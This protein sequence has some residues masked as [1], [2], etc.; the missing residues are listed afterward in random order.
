VFA[1]VAFYLQQHGW[2]SGQAWGRE[3]T[4][5]PSA[6]TAAAALPRRESGCRAER[7]MTAPAPLTR[8][9]RM[10]LRTV[11]GGP[12]PAGT[13]PASLAQSGT[14]SFLLYANYDALLGYNCAHT[15]ALSVALLAERLK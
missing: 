5:P 13:V 4:I 8:W 7:I 6:R 11:R 9:R 12:L 2:K 15:Y 3:V 14:R 10:G 1:S